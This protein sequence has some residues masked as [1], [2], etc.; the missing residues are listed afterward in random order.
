MTKTKKV[1]MNDK[2][3]VFGNKF[4]QPAKKKETKKATKKK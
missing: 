4:K 2:D 1:V 3:L